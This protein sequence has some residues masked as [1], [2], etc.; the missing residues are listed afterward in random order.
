MNTIWPTTDELSAKIKYDVLRGMHVSRPILNAGC[1]RRFNPAANCEAR[2]LLDAIGGP[3]CEN[4]TIEGEALY[5]GLCVHGVVNPA[6]D[7]TCPGFRPLGNLREWLIYLLVASTI[8]ARHS[9]T[10]RVEPCSSAI[11]FL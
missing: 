8:A 9:L 2:L 6:T 4:G 5:V 1:R 10:E 7:V 3:P 11:H